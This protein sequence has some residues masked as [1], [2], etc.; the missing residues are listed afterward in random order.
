MSHNNRLHRG[1]CFV[2]YDT[3]EEAERA[4]LRTNGLRVFGKPLVSVPEDRNKST[5]NMH[6]TVSLFH[7]GSR[8]QRGARLAL[9]ITYLPISN[10]MMSPFK[11]KPYR[12]AHLVGPHFSEIQNA[13]L[14][15][16]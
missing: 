14:A 3:R 7:Y 13:V 2:E 8:V 12:H 5:Q 16:S 15:R 11:R 6:V 10:F 1:Y 9:F 4:R